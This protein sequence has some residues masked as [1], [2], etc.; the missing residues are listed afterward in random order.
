LSEII[1][2]FC[3]LPNAEISSRGPATIEESKNHKGFTVE[4]VLGVYKIV[5][6]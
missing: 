2:K 4:V 5:A 1:G 3:K 6:I